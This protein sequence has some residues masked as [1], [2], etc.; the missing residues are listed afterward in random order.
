MHRVKNSEEVT[1]WHET[2]G[3]RE[4]GREE[5]FGGNEGERNRERK[6]RESEKDRERKREITTVHFITTSMELTDNSHKR[7]LE[8]LGGGEEPHRGR[9]DG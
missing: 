2:V 4:Q 9:F 1:L 7:L 5:R 6:K 8:C 3:K